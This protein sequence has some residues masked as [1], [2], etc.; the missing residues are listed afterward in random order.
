MAF[1]CFLKF[2]KAIATLC[3]CWHGSTRAFQQQNPSSHIKNLPPLCSI[4][5]STTCRTINDF[6]VCVAASCW[7][8]L[9]SMRDRKVTLPGW[10]ITGFPGRK[11]TS[12]DPGNSIRSW[13]SLLGGIVSIPANVCGA[14]PMNLFR[15]LAKTSFSRTFRRRIHCLRYVNFMF[16]VEVIGRR[17]TGTP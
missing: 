15:S 6:C 16:P 10:F 11:I 3:L 5:S 13:R 2:R 12:L 17:S 7:E 1:L 4:I 8:L 14:P 9:E